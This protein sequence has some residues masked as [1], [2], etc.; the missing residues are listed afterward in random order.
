MGRP[1]LI[2]GHKKSNK[3]GISDFLVIGYPYSE[4]TCNFIYVTSF[5]VLADCYSEYM[6]QAIQPL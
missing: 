4:N 3:K 1:E 6:V 5:T 2:S